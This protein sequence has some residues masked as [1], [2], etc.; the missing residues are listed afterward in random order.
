MPILFYCILCCYHY[1]PGTLSFCRVIC[2]ITSPPV[3]ISSCLDPVSSSM[4]MAMFICAV[5]WV[6][7]LKPSLGLLFSE[8]QI[9]VEN[10]KT[11]RP[12]YLIRKVLLSSDFDKRMNLKW[13]NPEVWIIETCAR[14]KVTKMI[15]LDKSNNKDEYEA[16]L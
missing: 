9:Q 5:R 14:S 1:P 4:T 8:L 16:S 6:A 15:G 10:S 3:P 12:E 11:Y 7:N 13:W 2:P